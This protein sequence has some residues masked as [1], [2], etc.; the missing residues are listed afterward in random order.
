MSPTLFTLLALVAAP[1]QAPDLTTVVRTTLERCVSEW[2]AVIGRGLDLADADRARPFRTERACGLTAE[3]WTGDDG[4]MVAAARAAVG[5]EGPDWTGTVRELRVNERGA[6]LWTQLEQV[7][8]WSPA[9]LLIIEP[10]PGE[11]GSVEIHF[12]PAGI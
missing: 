7:E 3:G 2:E 12:D 1:Q 5:A 8:G 9:S 11:S 10:P 4:A 6:A